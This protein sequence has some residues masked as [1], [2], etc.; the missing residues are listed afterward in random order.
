MKICIDCDDA[1]VNLKKVLYNHIKS[2]GIDITDLNYS[3][4]KENS[5]YPEIGFNLAKEVVAGNYDRGISIC[6]TGLGMAMIANK[7][8]GIFAGTCHD[9]FSAE[10]LRKSND[11]QIITMG[12]RVIG[13][14]LA[15][16]IIDAWLVSEFA[17]GGSTP[18][19]AQMRKLEKESFASN[20]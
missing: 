1:A 19:V 3:E 13:P 15:K 7:V 16:T 5:M 20:K 17:G 6:G 10:R 14:E 12:E 2:K 9:V 11:A 4:G 8:E 18:K